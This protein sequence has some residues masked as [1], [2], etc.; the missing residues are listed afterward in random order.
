[1]MCNKNE[2][3]KHGGIKY[4]ETRHSRSSKRREEYLI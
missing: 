2:L 1:M 4:Y 3:G